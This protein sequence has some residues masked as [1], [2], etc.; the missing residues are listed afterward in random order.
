M[1]SHDNIAASLTRIYQLFLEVGYI[2]EEQM[3]WPPHN[4]HDLRLD[5]AQGSGLSK[6]SI[7]LLKNIPWADLLSTDLTY[8]S[9]TVNYSDEDAFEACRHPIFPDHDTDEENPIIDGSF[10]PLSI[11][12]PQWGSTLI[13]NA[14]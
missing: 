2:K 12:T 1:S 4:D 10:L 13:V 3:K 5:L 11:A 6:S 14:D 8:E 9:N 7:E